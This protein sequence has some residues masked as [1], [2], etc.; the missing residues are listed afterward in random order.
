M[1]FFTANQL[2]LFPD[3]FFDAFATISSLHEMRREQVDHFLRL[4]GTKTRS[5]I[6]VKQ[7]RRYVNPHDGLLIERQ[8]YTFPTGWKI[9]RERCDIL[10]P[11]FFE[12]VARRH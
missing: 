2:E 3:C 5:V 12:V 11:G 6:Y 7:Q 4:M 9:A 8:D 1:A 10:N